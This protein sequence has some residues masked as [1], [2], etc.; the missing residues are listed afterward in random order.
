M[1]NKEK[2]MWCIVDIFRIITIFFP[3][4][5]QYSLAN[6]VVCV[7]NTLYCPAWHES[8]S[9]CD[10][11]FSVHPSFSKDVSKS[12][13]LPFILLIFY[14]S[15]S[16]SMKVALLFRKLIHLFFNMHFFN[17]T[18][19]HIFPLR[20]ISSPIKFWKEGWV[21]QEKM[22]TLIMDRTN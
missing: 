11:G 1:N 5:W 3:Y 16:I 21:L 12:K 17:A 9:P 20:L 4:Y 2:H 8:S 18:S 6:P 7:D 22:F 19:H 15:L 13:P 14:A 10:W